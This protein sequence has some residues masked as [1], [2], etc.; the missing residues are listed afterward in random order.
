VT[1]VKN[2]IS[3][4]RAVME[5]S[6]HVLLVGAGAEWFVLSEPIKTRYRIER[7]SNIYFRTEQR[8]NELQEELRKEE[9]QRREGA[10]PRPRRHLGTVGAVAL[11][12]NGDLAAGT[13]T[14]RMTNKWSGRVGDDEKPHVAVL[15]KTLK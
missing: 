3:A 13:S 8:W 9:K 11:D 2:P 10:A 1:H 6:P 7:V 12:G 15:D 5:R 4:A 14:G